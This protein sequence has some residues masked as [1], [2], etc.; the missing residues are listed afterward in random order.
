MKKIYQVQVDVAYN[1]KI[2]VG[3]DENENLVA[4]ECFDCVCDNFSGKLDFRVT[5][6]EMR[7]DLKGD[8]ILYNYNSFDIDE[9][10]E[11]Y[12]NEVNGKLKPLV[13]LDTPLKSYLSEETIRKAVR[14]AIDK[15][16]E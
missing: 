6:I 3:E 4:K 15:N 11:E 10:V 7:P 13:I 12:Y 2:V 5:E 9:F 8:E 1:Y 16:F 14:F